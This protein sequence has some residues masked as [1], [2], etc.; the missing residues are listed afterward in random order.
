MGIF[1]GDIY[2]R[3]IESLSVSDICISP[4]FYY[5]LHIIL[6]PIYVISIFL[7]FLFPYSHPIS[8]DIGR[9]QYQVIFFI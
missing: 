6:L 1:L 4:H 9:G 2:G 3:P 8:C 5:F 7:Y